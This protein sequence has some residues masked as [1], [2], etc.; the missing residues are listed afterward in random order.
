[1]G[2]P[3]DHEPEYESIRRTGGQDSPPA[4]DEPEYESIRRTGGDDEGTS[5]DEEDG[6]PEHSE[7]AS[8]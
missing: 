2:M 8:E 7:P 3:D 1:M 5:G 6:P 4:E